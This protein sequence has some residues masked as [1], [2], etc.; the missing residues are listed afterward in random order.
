M[1]GLTSDVTNKEIEEHLSSCE[2]CR[3]TLDKM[4][5][6][7]EKEKETKE[8]ETKEIDYLYKIKQHTKR[9]L[10]VGIMITTL[11]IF[12]VIGIRLYIMG[13][14]DNSVAS[15]E[16]KMSNVQSK[17]NVD[18]LVVQGTLEN[19]A[20]VYLKH[21]IAIENDTVV[22]SLSER[23]A[24]P[25]E[26]NNEFYIA[27]VIP[28]NISKVYLEDKVIWENGN[29]ISKNTNDL[30]E[31]KH[32]YIGDM[33]ANGRVIN[34]LNIVEKFGNFK[35]SLQTSKEPY[36]WTL[37]FEEIVSNEETFNDLMTQYS[38]IILALIENLG[39]VFWQYNNGYEVVTKY[40]TLQ[41]AKE[42]LGENVKDFTQSISKLQNLIDMLYLN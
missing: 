14:K 34:Q 15:Y 12:M 32:A 38:Y 21:Q 26:N 33:S 37:E 9:N 1:D 39:E 42:A 7:L 3:D 11:M 25:W 18:C 5:A 35:N 23:L 16:V 31:T 24:F 41:D 19:K 4:T 22:I 10:V 8:M 29:L 2:E 13:F 28:D 6:P 17:K 30:Y 20:M 27:Y 36:G 40:V